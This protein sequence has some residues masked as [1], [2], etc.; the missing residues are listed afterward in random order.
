MLLADT[1]LAARHIGSLIVQ[2]RQASHTLCTLTRMETQTM[3]MSTCAYRSSGAHPSVPWH[4]LHRTR[5]RRFFESSSQ[6]R[7]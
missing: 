6:M 7:S 3:E 4:M 5:Y 2:A 1:V